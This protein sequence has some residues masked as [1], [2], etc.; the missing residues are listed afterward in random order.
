MVEV[1]IV[2][3]PKETLDKEWNIAWEEEIHERPKSLD[4]WYPIEDYIV[5]VLKEGEDEGKPVA[6]MGYTNKG[7]YALYGDARTHPKYE[8]QGIYGKLVSYRDGIV[9]PPK[10]AGFRPRRQ[11]LEDYIAWQESKGWIENPSDKEI[12]EHFGQLPEKVVNKFRSFYEDDPK[13]SWGI[14]KHMD[15]FT[16]AWLIL[17]KDFEPAGE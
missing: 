5:A 1:D 7:D 14:R 17:L 13:A 2:S 12:A 9:S 10:F 11:N 6:Y 8:K 15:A 4:S 3:W 16:K